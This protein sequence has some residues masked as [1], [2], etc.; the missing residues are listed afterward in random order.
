MKKFA[1]VSLISILALTGCTN[2]KAPNVEKKITWEHAGNLPAQKGFEKNIGVAGVLSGTLENKYVVV[3]GGANFPF[4]PVAVGG[5][6]KTYSDIYLLEADGSKLNTVD[7][8]NWIN[9]IGYGASVTTKDGVYY[10]G[11]STN[12]EGDNDILLVKVVEGKLKVEKIGDL[13]FTLQNG[14]AVEKDGKLYV[15]AGKQDGQATNKLWSYDLATKEVKELAPIPG[16]SGR[17]Q[18][19]GQILNGELYVFGGGTSVAYTDGYKYNF[20]TNEW[21]KVASVELD[22]KGISVLGANSVKLNDSE[23]LVIGG[24]DKAIWDDANYNLGTLKGKKLEQYKAGYFGADPK[25]F[26]WNKNILVYNAT[27]NEWRTLGEIPFDAPC[28]EGL[29]IINNKIYSINGE[30]KPGVRTDRMFAGTILR[31]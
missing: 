25:D 29:A 16:A 7:H 26:N 15:F 13:P 5:A 8:I 21:T 3:G 27:K 1:L 20:L 17:T 23:M 19:V 12:P 18:A 6:K 11:G 31:K 30:I 22:G 24:F 14:G 9:E 28:G 4:E 10:L 2:V